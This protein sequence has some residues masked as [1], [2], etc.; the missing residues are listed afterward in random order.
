MDKDTKVGLIVLVL[1]FAAIGGLI[2]A[3]GKERE[4]EIAIY[5]NLKQTYIQECVSN[6][7]SDKSLTQMEKEIR[8]SDMFHKHIVNS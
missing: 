2:F 5:N 6:G 8:C 4:K 1:W 7:V 3:G